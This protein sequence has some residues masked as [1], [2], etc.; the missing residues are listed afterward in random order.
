MLGSSSLSRVRF[1]LADEPPQHRNEIRDGAAG[2]GRGSKHHDDRHEDQ[3]SRR[4][5]GLRV[6]GEL[7]MQ[8]YNDGGGV[9]GPKQVTAGEARRLAI[10]KLRPIVRCARPAS[11]TELR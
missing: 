6:V 11:L 5:V 9:R 2:D 4:E 8:R 3:A 1:L 10:A 7:P